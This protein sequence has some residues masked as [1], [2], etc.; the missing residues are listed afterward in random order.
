MNAGARAALYTAE[1]STLKTC[2]RHAERA[3]LRVVTMIE[4]DPD[5]VASRLGGAKL[6]A[7]VDRLGDG[8]FEVIVADAGSGRVVT[9]AAALSDEADDDGAASA[10]GTVVD[11]KPSTGGRAAPVPAE[12]TAVRCAIYTRC[13]THDATN[14]DPFAAQIKA[15]QAYT[16]KQGWETVAIYKDIAVSGMTS[17]RPGLDAMIA[18]LEQ[19]SFDVVL[20]EDSDRLGRNLSHV[21]R[22]LKELEAQGVAVH[23][24]NCGVID[25]LEVALRSS[26]SASIK[27]ERSLR[28]RH[29]HAEAKRRKAAS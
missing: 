7:L 6:Q 2:A 21:Y 10:V 27:R 11:E 26:V 28:A 16:A 19:G 29:G 23:T 5:G 9:I 22:L 20:V 1:G 12:G 3:G 17:S 24:V 8:E 14:P 15:C 4:E 18:Q 13:A 25:D